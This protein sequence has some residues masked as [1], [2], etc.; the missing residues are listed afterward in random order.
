MLR[1]SDAQLDDLETLAWSRWVDRHV[2]AMADLLPD[3]VAMYPA[4]VF[5]RRVDALLRRADLHGM[6]RQPE[7]VA[8]CYGSLQFGVGFEA[9]A[10]LPG[11]A[12]A[13]ALSGAP[14]AEALWDAFEASAG[15]AGEA[16]GVAA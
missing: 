5:A 3:V 6:D 13:M 7:T 4:D 8:Y 9:R 14:R 15:L 11:I 1:I 2:T 10:D 16:A 12:Q